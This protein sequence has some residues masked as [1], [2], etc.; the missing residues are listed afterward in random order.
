MKADL[1]IHTHYSDGKLT[2]ADVA[3]LA[4]RAG[5][6]I[7]SV[8]DHDT[9]C[10]TAE[11]EKQCAEAGIKFV[12][13]IEV[14]AYYGDVK[15]HTLGYGMD[16]ENTTFKSFLKALK[17]G[18]IKRTED[19]IFKL[20]RAG[21]ALT[22]EDAAAERYSAETPLH[23]MHI[24]GAGAKK[25]YASSPF[26]FF[27]KYLAYGR[28]AFS[29]V[30]RPSPEETAQII[31]AAGGIC[32]LAH[33]ARIDLSAEEKIALIK[34]MKVCGL[35]GI[36]AVYSGHTAKETAYYKEIANTFGLMVTGGSDTHTAE[37]NR[38]IGTPYFQPENALLQKLG[39]DKKDI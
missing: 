33:P 38:Q 29:S 16:L 37:G 2:P 39:F 12:R 11:A 23:A 25:G 8:T 19:I 31:T 1:H 4:L 13:G 24:A 10:G 28:P 17:D 9:V 21:V 20:N 3:R 5:V 7:I 32:S 18:S 27:T 36:E 15:I 34:R 26:A 6:E 35:C 14:S 22:F 30:C